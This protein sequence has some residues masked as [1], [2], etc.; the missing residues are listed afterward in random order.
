MA[1]KQEHTL[2]QL[3]TMKRDERRGEVEELDKK[4]APLREKMDAVLA[5][6]EALRA[7][8][9]EPLLAQWRPLNEQR[10]AIQNEESKA[11]KSVGGLSTSRPVPAVTTAPADA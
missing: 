8:K 3:I 5:E 1:A 10:Q 9:L 7:G 11:A 4:M 2:D 6:I